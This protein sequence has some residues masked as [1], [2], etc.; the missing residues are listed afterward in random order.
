MSMQEFSMLTQAL[1]RLED[2]PVVVSVERCLNRRHKEAGCQHCIDLCPK[3]AVSQPECIEVDF[4][5]CVAC[6]L[7][8]RVCP[9]EV[10]TLK[11]IDDR[12]LFA[13]IGSLLSQGS[14]IEV[15]CSL[16]VKDEAVRSNSQGILELT[17]LG[18]LSPSLLIGGI[19]AG[20]ELIWVND[21]LCPEC[22]HSSV[23][24]I[25]K[26]TVA[27]SRNLLRAFGREPS[28]FS[29]QDSMGLLPVK[30]TSRNTMK[31]NAEQLSYSRR[32]LFRSLGRRATREMA[33]IASNMI[34]NILPAPAT[35]KL[36][37]QYLLA[38]RLLLAKLLLK[39]GEPSKDILNLVGLPM[40]ELKISEQCSACGLCC[41]FCPTGAL[42]SE[43][44]DNDIKLTFATIYC[45]ACGIC[46]KVCPSN[47]IKFSYEIN[48]TRLV[49]QEPEILMRCKATSCTI[50]DAPCTSNDPESLCFVCQKRSEQR[51]TLSGSSLGLR[52]L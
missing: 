33:E 38:Q 43:A 14:S 1:S 45:V 39:L 11:A 6:G 46:Q 40:A 15:A 29:Y 8:W 24:S 22:Q 23:Y 34:E 16:V 51:E 21:S 30:R 47:S 31:V 18:Q 26:N 13:Q 49:E 37:E 41:K 50:C 9:T 44:S 27:T 10:F 7:C 48:T 20:E 5:K 4:E 36:L 17:C 12:K 2:R 42:Q 52:G 19:V 35:P 25:V 3:Q 32:D 28:I